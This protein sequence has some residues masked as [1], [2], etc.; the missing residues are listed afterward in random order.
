MIKVE[1]D[2]RSV[3]GRGRKWHWRVQEYGLKGTSREPLLDACREL[4]KIGVP[5]GAEVGTYR[6]GRTEWDL[7]TTVGYGASRTV[8]ENETQGPRFVKYAPFVRGTSQD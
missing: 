8:S 6:P 4:L 5:R 2:E 1:R 3:N 7:R